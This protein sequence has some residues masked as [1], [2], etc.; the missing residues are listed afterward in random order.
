MLWNVSFSK[1]KIQDVLTTKALQSFH[2][3][4]AAFTDAVR[5]QFMQH[6]PYR[7]RV[8]QQPCGLS[9][10]PVL[11]DRLELSRIQERVPICEVD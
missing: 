3:Q 6:A 4:T 5:T 8:R 7:C 2:R 10:A 11:V 1:F 9:H